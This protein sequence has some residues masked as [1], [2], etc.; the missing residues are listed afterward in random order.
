MKI[1]FHLNCLERGGAERVVSTL[2][3]SM[4]SRGEEVVIATEW[5]GDE[6]YAL[7]ERVKR[8]I[9]G[10]RKEDENKGRLTVAYL[11]IKYLKDCIKEEKPDIVIAFA[12]KAGYRLLMANRFNRVPSMIAV[13]IDPVG[14]YD[15]R[16]DRFIQPFIYPRADGCVF[17]TT[18]QRDFFPEYLQKKS[19]I[20][21]NPVNDKYLN[22]RRVNNPEKAIINSSRI[23]DFKNQKML[24]EAFSQVLKKHPDYRLY[25]YGGDAKDGTWQILEN[26][27]REHRLEEKVFL[28]GESDSLEQIIPKCE[29]YVLSSDEEG[30]PNSLLE[31]MT[32]G[33]P[34]V[35]TDCS[36]GGARA[37]IE[38]GV[39]GLLV[40][41]R[42]RDAMAEAICRLIEDK[43]LADRLGEN[44]SHITDIIS[45]DRITDQWLDYIRLVRQ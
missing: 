13:R 11:R 24:I 38:D 7:D 34:V 32:M 20:I 40:P 2:A 26:T 17:Q 27:I 19:S 16:M 42:D 1:M 18:A 29:I 39:N 30:M 25:F 6:E 4:V 31:A 9:V 44:A 12:R 3:N 15:G 14:A 8:I 43:A 37:V 33:M 10:P 22:S 45:S 5:K 36:G 35:S 28:C 23:V 21:L 41:V